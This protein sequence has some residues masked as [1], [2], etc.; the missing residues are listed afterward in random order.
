MS[1]SWD[2]SYSHFSSGGPISC[3]CCF[4]SHPKHS[5]SRRHLK[6]SAQPQQGAARAVSKPLELGQLALL[7]LV[8]ASSTKWVLGVGMET[9]RAGNKLCCVGKVTLLSDYLPFCFHPLIAMHQR[10]RRGEPA[11]ST[12][13]GLNGCWEESS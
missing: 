4:L 12:W 7:L 9:F 5:I 10:N 2:F 11:S 8:P 1:R 6:I 3:S 13:F